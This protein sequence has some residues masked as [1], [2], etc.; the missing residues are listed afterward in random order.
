MEKQN[1]KEAGQLLKSC[2]VWIIGSIIIFSTTILVV[3]WC[4][5]IFRDAIMTELQI[6]NGTNNFAMWQR[7]SVRVVYK[8]HL[9]NYTNVEDF[10][11]DR[12][13]K[14]RVEDIGPYI[15]RETLQRV[16]PVF[17]QNGTISYQEVRSYQWE[18]GR[19]D[20][21]ILVVPNFLLFAAM[22]YLRDY[23]YIYHFTFTTILAGLRAKRFIKL[24]AG[25]FLWGYDDELFNYGKPFISMKQHIPFEKFGL[26]ALKPGLSNDRFT[27]NT[28]ENDM[29]KLGIIERL[30]GMESREIW[31]DEECDKITGTDGSIFPPKLIRDPNA[32]LHIYSKEICR[33]VPLK[34]HGHSSAQGIPTMRYVPVD[35]LFTASETKN[36]CYCQRVRDKEKK[37]FS[38]ASCP[39]MGV[40]NASACNFGMPT[41]TSYPHFY[42]GDKLLIEQ[43]DGLNPQKELHETFIDLHPH[44]GVPIGGHSRIQ[45]NLEARK[46]DGVPYFGK[47]KDGTILPLMWMEAAIENIPDPV[48][49]LLSHAYYTV[50]IVDQIFKWGSVVSL[51]LS[52]ASLYHILRK[53]Q[54]EKHIVLHRNTSGQNPLL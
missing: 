47:I 11:N 2:L 39:P 43:F 7:P 52:L 16:N 8:I 50:N 34:F 37:V 51:I 36:Y 35:D 29:D 25:E 53:K 12:A 27:I 20:E 33:T 32:T 44:L 9:F 13:E 23:P 49:S 46:A 26:L 42:Q 14:L 17:H 19:S 4:T 31:G 15:Y 1:V 18:G 22:A 5:N 48:L 54:L 21:E 24:S 41:L 30:N 6:K 10:E 40:F 45:L 3:F 38:K 28:G